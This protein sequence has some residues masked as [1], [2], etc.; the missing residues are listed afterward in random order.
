MSDS[1]TYYE[2]LLYKELSFCINFN[3]NWLGCSKQNL[4]CSKLCFVCVALRRLRQKRLKILVVLS[5]IHNIPRQT[6]YYLN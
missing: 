2:T 1:D 3:E 5:I 4:N 6:S